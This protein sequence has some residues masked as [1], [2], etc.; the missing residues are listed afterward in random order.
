[1]KRG[2]ETGHRKRTGTTA[3]YTKKKKKEKERRK[4]KRKTRSF[5]IAGYESQTVGN[6]LSFWSMTSGRCSDVLS[7]VGTKRKKKMCF[8]RLPVF[9]FFFFFPH[10]GNAVHFVHLLLAVSQSRRRKNNHHWCRVFSP[11]R[12]T[13]SSSCVVNKTKQNKKNAGRVTTIWCHPYLKSSR[14]VF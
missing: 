13:V 11:G 5:H 1:M 12:L 8:V 14:S 2:L 9:R 6:V 7:N 10:P 4:K 3:A